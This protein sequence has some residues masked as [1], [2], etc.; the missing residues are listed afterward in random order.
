MNV[1][2]PVRWLHSP[3]TDSTAI[4]GRIT[5]IGKPKAAANELKVTSLSGANTM[6]APVARSAA[7]PML[8]I[9]QKPE[10]VSNILRSST[11]TTRRSGMG[12]GV[13]RGVRA[14]PACGS[15]VTAVL[16]L[17]LLLVGCRR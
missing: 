12:R 2:S 5:A 17:L 9:S 15:V 11:E 6:T 16:M 4:I 3:V 1:E 10:R 13:G 8:A 14:R 7:I